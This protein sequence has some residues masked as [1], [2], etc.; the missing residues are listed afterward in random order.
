[1]KSYTGNANQP[2]V[3]LVTAFE[4]FGGE[5][6]NPTEIVLDKLPDTIDG[7]AL[8]K[9]LLPVEFVRARELAFAAYDEKAPAAVVML[10]QAGGRSAI[11]PETTDRNTMNSR[12]PDNAGFRPDHQPV[13]E[14]GPDALTSTLPVEKIMEAVSSIGIPC[15]KSDNAGE[16][17]C[18]ALLYGMLAHNNGEV[19]TGFIH[20]PFIREQGH[21][22]R[23]YLELD[24]ILR[25][26]IAAIKAVIEEME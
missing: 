20:V 21:A 9:M 8:K 19:P 11:T 1:M 4:P 10:G 6:L 16:Y 15:E 2:K 18:N 17:V 12:V 23:P 26:V 24:D 13:A 3:I 5:K 14:N 25:G 7:Y 22:D